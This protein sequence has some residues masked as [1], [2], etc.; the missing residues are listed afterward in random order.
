M[1]LTSGIPGQ[2][3][4]FYLV[5]AEDAVS[6]Y[7]TPPLTEEEKQR[8]LEE[9]EEEAAK[10][11]KGKKGGK[12]EPAASQEELDV[13]MES[14][15]APEPSPYLVRKNR[16]SIACAS[17][18]GFCGSFIVNQEKEVI[19]VFSTERLITFFCAGV[20]SILKHL[21]LSSRSSFDESSTPSA[22]DVYRALSKE[23]RN[24]E[25]LRPS[26][27][28]SLRSGGGAGVGLEE[29]SATS[30]NTSAVG[31]KPLGRGSTGNK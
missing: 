28:S 20:A 3:I 30:K 2:R 4:E 13:D 11:T 1:S 27:V 19:S 15:V 26:A 17:A 21:A 7:T 9:A 29:T 16:T 8:L 10:A 5:P 18:S 31:K 14:L 24:M 6:T 12:K 25:N 23:E 22:L